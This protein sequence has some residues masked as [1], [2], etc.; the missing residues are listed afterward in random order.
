MV[1]KTRLHSYQSAHFAIS[2]P[3][4]RFI[5]GLIVLVHV[6]ACVYAGI[7]LAHEGSWLEKYQVRRRGR[8]MRKSSQN[9]LLS[10]I[11]VFLLVEGGLFATNHLVNMCF[12][13]L[14][15]RVVPFV[16]VRKCL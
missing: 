11:L 6:G 2:G 1:L 5:L 14:S 10:E 4:F 7:G 12:Y 13:E 3:S 16:W 15:V 9:E 8:Q